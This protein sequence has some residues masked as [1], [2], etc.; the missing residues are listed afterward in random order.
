VQVPFRRFGSQ[1][2]YLHMLHPHAPSAVFFC[3]QFKLDA[4]V[5]RSGFGRSR[6]F[7]VKYMYTSI[8]FFASPRQPKRDR[9]YNFRTPYYKSNDVPRVPIRL[10]KIGRSE[11]TSLASYFGGMESLSAMFRDCREENDVQKDILQEMFLLMS[12]SGPFKIPVG[13][14]VT[15][16]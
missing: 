4:A 11:V 15:V 16:A 8:L 3:G 2:H 10:A 7:V 9:R 14:C 1:L 13:T 12:S 6:F 5:F